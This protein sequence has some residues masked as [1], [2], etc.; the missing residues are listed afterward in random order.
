MRGLPRLI[1]K[2]GL[3]A[4]TVLGAAGIAFWATDFA[5]TSGSP[6]AVIPADTFAIR[7]PAALNEDAAP[8]A[9][10]WFAAGGGGDQQFALFSPNPTY[11]LTAA[12]FAPDT[13]AR[14]RPELT[15]TGTTANTATSPA[16]NA[17][18][19]PTVFNDAQIAS[20]KRRLN[21]TK[22]QEEYWPAVEAMLRGLAWKK[23]ANDAPRKATGAERPLLALDVNSADLA[24][25]QSTAGPLLM[26][27]NEEQKREL[28]MLAHLA[29]LQGAFSK[30]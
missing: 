8:P 25:L 10:A 14:G 20:I 26:S 21:L 2:L 3:M 12:S 6:P 13:G 5:A 15:G 29:G 1:S 19:K 17:N 27:F 7:F 24:R 28:R 4:I 11:A 30:F 23:P 22:D 16:R 9:P 18:R